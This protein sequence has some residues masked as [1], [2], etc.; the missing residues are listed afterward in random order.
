[1]MGRSNLA[2]RMQAN[3]ELWMTINLTLALLMV[4]IGGVLRFVLR[5]PK[6]DFMRPAAAVT[7]PAEN[8]SQMLPFAAR[9]EYSNG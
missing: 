5:Q 8:A 1:M 4:L 2:K 9:G 3:A 6:S 7:V